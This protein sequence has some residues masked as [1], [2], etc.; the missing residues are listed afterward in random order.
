MGNLFVYCQKRL[1]AGSKLRT[2]A[3]PANAAV[4]G[5]GFDG[6]R[7]LVLLHAILQTV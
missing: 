5:V 6:A 1:L 2:S 7:D 4:S 3:L